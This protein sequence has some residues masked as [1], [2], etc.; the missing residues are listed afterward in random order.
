M[1]K[2]GDDRSIS[3]LLNDISNWKI[4]PK[5]PVKEFNARFNKLLNKIH[6]DSQPS[7]QV[8]IEW[9][10]TALPSNIEIFVDRAE[11][12]TLAE[13]MKEAIA[14]EKRITSLEKKNSIEERKSKKVSFKYDSKKK[15]KDP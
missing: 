11:K 5:E 2:F 12:P 15:A 13:N 6:I 1:T 8:R 9:Y 4:E 3:T 10:I 7:E 14:V